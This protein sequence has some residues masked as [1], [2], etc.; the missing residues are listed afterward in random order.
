MKQNKS[1]YP[2]HIFEPIRLEIAVSYLKGELRKLFSGLRGKSWE[3]LDKEIELLASNPNLAFPRDF[4]NGIWG[5]AM[6]FKLKIGMLDYITAENVVWKKENLSVSRFQFGVKFHSKNHLPLSAQERI[7]YYQKN[8]VEVK[9]D[10]QK[11]QK[12]S[13]TS[14]SRD[15]LPIIAME[16]IVKGQLVLSI[17]DGNR[18]LQKAILEERRKIL[19]YTGKFRTKK[20]VP[21]NFWLPTPLIMELVWR[22]KSC[23]DE[24]KT[25]KAKKILTTLRSFLRFSESGWYE[26]ENRAVTSNEK[27]NQFMIE[28]LRKPVS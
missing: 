5:I 24:E 28:F 12:L 19:A 13:K 9:K 23:F 26:L 25:I 8:P 14:E 22:A 17:Y 2:K 1:F 10:Y 7:V 27:F 3:K 16:K 21:L 15:E 11:A 20:K 18:R 6:G 4:W